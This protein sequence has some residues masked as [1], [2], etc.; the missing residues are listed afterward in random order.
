MF[1]RKSEIIYAPGEISHIV[2]WVRPESVQPTLPRL[3]D[4]TRQWNCT[5]GIRNL[6]AGERA[7][8]LFFRRKEFSRAI[9][10][11]S[12]RAVSDDTFLMRS[13][14]GEIKSSK[15][16]RCVRPETII[17]P[18]T[19]RPVPRLILNYSSRMCQSLTRRALI[20]NYYVGR[21]DANKRSK[22]KTLIT[23]KRGFYCS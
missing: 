13:S 10:S 11:L 6:C 20:W 7:N 2:T 12:A 15:S 9:F 4:T 5:S 14:R 23:Y 21:R 19:L 16:S 17:H 1:V 18:C 22:I 3:L 8:C